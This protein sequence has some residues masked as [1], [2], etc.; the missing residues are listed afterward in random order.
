MSTNPLGRLFG[1]SPFRPIQAHMKTVASCA[2]EVEPLLAAYAA[3]DFDAMREHRRK[4]DDL[5]GQ[6]DRQK[7]E[8]RGQLPKSLFL[9]VDRRD[10][11]ELLHLQD[12][13]ADAAQDVAE[14][15]HLGPPPALPDSFRTPLNGLSQSSLAAVR[16]AR[17]AIDELDELLETGFRGREADGVETVLE[18][19]GRLEHAADR[20]ERQLMK[21]L[22]RDADELGR[23]DFHLW[24]ELIQKLGKLADFAEDVA[25]RLRLL[26]A[27]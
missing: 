20:E 13:I 15:L 19:V 3:G 25:D 23:A 22:L 17:T 21:L 5:E 27:R 1:P 18:E 14:Y 24:Y 2:A 6:A 12:S 10:L 16:A 4:I 9:P 26:I 7:N 8:L 11:L